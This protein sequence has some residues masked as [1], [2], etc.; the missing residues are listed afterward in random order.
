M[1]LSKVFVQFATACEFQNQENPLAIVEVPIEPQ[2]VRV[3]KIALNLNLAPN[4]FLH[5]SLLQFGLVKD[6]ECAN[7]AGRPLLRQVDSAK[8][9]LSQGLANL[10]H[11]KVEFL[12]RRLLVG[13][14]LVL[15]GIALN[16]GRASGIWCIDP[17]VIG[18]LQGEFQ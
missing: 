16:G 3:T 9:A 7:E 14:F 11:S 2:D 13:L 12:R 4:L 8:F 5:P 17:V 6:L 1:F 15:V 18:I 10:E